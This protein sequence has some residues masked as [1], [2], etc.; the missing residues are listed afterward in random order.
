MFLKIIKS[1]NQRLDHNKKNLS[2]LDKLRYIYILNMMLNKALTD[3]PD[4]HPPC[5]ELQFL[6]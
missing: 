3:V 4:I 5:L 1:N 2:H 6:F